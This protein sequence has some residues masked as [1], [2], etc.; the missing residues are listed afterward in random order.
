MGRKG[1]EKVYGIFNVDGKLAKLGNACKYYR[2]M[3][4]HF[5]EFVERRGV[6][7]NMDGLTVRSPEVIY[8]VRYGQGKGALT[9]KARK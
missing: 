9:I 7:F 2:W 3:F 6:A 5:Y 8:P 1:K 4:F